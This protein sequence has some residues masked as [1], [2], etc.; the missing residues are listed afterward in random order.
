MQ[1]LC[2]KFSD[3][4]DQ[5]EH[6]KWLI[7]EGTMKKLDY[8]ITQH[9]FGNMPYYVFIFPK[10]MDNQLG[11]QKIC[12]QPRMSKPSMIVPGTT[13]VRIDPMLADQMKIIWMLPHPNEINKYKMNKSLYKKGKV[14]ASEM[15]YNYIDD[16]LNNQEK[17]LAPEPGDASDEQMKEIYKD[18]LNKMNCENKD[19]TPDQSSQNH[20]S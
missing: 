4:M 19:S 18:I 5:K 12:M 16:Y 10:R 9:P 3:L 2:V 14:F 13:L 7:T 20:V 8:I 15:I 6:L 11:I 1:Q 17:L